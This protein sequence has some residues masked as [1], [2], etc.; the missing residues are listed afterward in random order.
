MNTE[1]LTWIY[2][3]DIDSLTIG[4]GCIVLESTSG[5]RISIHHDQWDPLM[6]DL[7]L[8][9]DTIESRDLFTIISLNREHPECK[10]VVAAQRNR[11]NIEDLSKSLEMQAGLNEL[12]SKIEKYTLDLANPNPATKLL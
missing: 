5:D 9:G 12:N 4:A 11:E 10:K 6:V 2:T 7:C 1:Q 3:N 8:L